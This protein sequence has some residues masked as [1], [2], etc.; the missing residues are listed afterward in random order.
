MEVYCGFS[1]NQPQGK[2]MF[3][4]ASVILFTIALMATQV[5]AHPSYSEVG[6]HQTGMLS[7]LILITSLYCAFLDTNINV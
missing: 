7:C 5:T 6:M 1:N 3:S 4:Q 2:V